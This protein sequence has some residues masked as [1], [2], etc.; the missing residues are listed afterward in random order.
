MWLPR[1]GHKRHFS[2]HL[3]PCATHSGGSLL[4]CC[5]DFSALWGDHIVRNE[6]SCQQPWKSAMLEADPLAVVKQMR[7]ALVM[8]TTQRPQ[9][10]PP[11]YSDM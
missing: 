10:K 4:P 9:A 11:S 3:A 8:L 6:A 1:L 5:T 7:G 2:L